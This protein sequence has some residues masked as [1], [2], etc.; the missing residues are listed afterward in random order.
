MWNYNQKLG[1]F[2]SLAQVLIYTVRTGHRKTNLQAL[3]DAWWKIW[4]S[5][6]DTK[7]GLSRALTK[8]SKSSIILLL[9]KDWHT[10]PRL[11]SLENVALAMLWK[12][13]L[14]YLTLSKTWVSLKAY[15]KLKAKIKFC[16]YGSTFGEGRK[17]IKVN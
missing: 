17:I 13:S 8:T 6:L 3:V 5:L 11:I 12:T 4:N 15:W 14:D 16:L 9:V 10:K 7:Q 1:L 2:L